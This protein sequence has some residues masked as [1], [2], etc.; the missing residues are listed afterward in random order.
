MIEKLITLCTANGSLL[1]LLTF[2]DLAIAV[3][4]FAIPI[5]MAVVLRHRRDDIPYPWLWTLFVTFIVACG[6]THA[7]HVWSALSGVEQLGF[8]TA[9]GLVTAAASVATAIAFS[10]ILPQLKTLPSPRQQREILEIM[11]AER[12]AEKQDLIDE[13]N[14]RIG[15]QLQ[16]LSGL[17][18][19]EKKANKQSSEIATVLNRFDTELRKMAHVHLSLSAGNYGETSK[20]N[21]QVS[22]TSDK[23]HAAAKPHNLDAASNL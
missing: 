1:W 3:S 11:V 15:N 19:L 16:V 9:I 6:L 22:S 13:I 14:H 18:H 12:T 17:V 7:V 20:A 2:S 23:R 10:F 21:A 8:Q 5:V 4:Y